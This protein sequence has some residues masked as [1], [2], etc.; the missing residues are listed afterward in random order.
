LSATTIETVH[1]CPRRAVTLAR[2][3]EGA[4]ERDENAPFAAG[5]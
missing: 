5:K 4:T 3:L 2:R 1:I